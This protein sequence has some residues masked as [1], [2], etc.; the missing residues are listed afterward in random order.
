MPV[1]LE[2]DPKTENIDFERKFRKFDDLIEPA[3]DEDAML[4]ELIEESTPVINENFS[5]AMVKC[6]TEILNSAKIEYLDFLYKLENPTEIKTFISQN[7]YLIKIIYNAKDQIERY[8]GYVTSHIKLHRD[9]EERWNELFI[10]IESPYSVE[11]TVEMEDK[12]ADDWFLNVMDTTQGKL[13]II[14]IPK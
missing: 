9:P 8:F 12:L 2:I 11:K 6:F 1:L 3:T 13:N 14:A 5:V 4:S 10:I 7:S